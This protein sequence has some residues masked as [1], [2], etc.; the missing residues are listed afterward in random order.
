MKKFDFKQV[1]NFDVHIS[2]SIP[3]FDDLFCMIYNISQFYIKN[4][5]S[6]LDL[7]CATGKLASALSKSAEEIHVFGLDKDDYVDSKYKNDFKFIQHTLSSDHPIDIFDIQFNLII[8]NFTLQFVPYSERQPI[9][10]DINNKL[11]KDG[12]FILTEKNS[13]RKRKKSNDV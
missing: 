11:T 8:S 13:P 2:R 9:L 6:V 12:C 1:D 10:I 4:G 5:S 7:G 3:A